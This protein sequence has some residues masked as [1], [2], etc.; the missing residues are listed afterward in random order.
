MLWSGT[1]FLTH[2]K[3]G[4]LRMIHAHGTIRHHQIGSVI[5]IMMKK[6]CLKITP[7]CLEPMHRLVFN[8]ILLLCAKYFKESTIY[9][10]YDLSVLYL[11]IENNSFKYTI[12]ILNN[13]RWYC[14]GNIFRALV[15]YDCMTIMKRGEREWIHNWWNILF[16][17]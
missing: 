9:I 8:H 6:W 5:F 7:S 2:T 10:Y 4:L 11:S 13:A 1:W 16:D 3:S 14:I 12:L 17:K 15:S